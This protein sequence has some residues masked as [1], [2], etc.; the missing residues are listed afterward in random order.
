MT[1]IQH[2]S[3]GKYVIDG[4]NYEYD[5]KIIK[6]KISSWHDHNL[7]LKD[8]KDL[9]EAKP[10]IIIIGTGAE[11]VI[12]VSE[13]IKNYIESKGIKLII[14]K[15]GEACKKYNKLEKQGKNVAAILHGTC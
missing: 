7:S 4:R 10:E 15:T 12:D 3:F 11:G 5:I 8:V 9:T 6:G 1:K 14:E 2:Y 13:E